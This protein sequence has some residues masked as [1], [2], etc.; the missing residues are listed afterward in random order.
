MWCL[1]EDLHSVGLNLRMQEE[2]ES[3][4][5]QKDRKQ[6]VKEEPSWAGLR[7]E[8]IDSILCLRMISLKAEE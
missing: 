4:G 1:G 5:K 6:K 2:Q 8:L 3:S 7:S